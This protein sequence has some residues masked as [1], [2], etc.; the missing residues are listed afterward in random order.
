MTDDGM[1]AEAKL[2]EVDQ[3]NVSASLP[4]TDA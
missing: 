3:A 1:M 4:P 2:S